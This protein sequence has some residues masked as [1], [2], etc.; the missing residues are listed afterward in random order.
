LSGSTDGLVNIIDTAVADEDEALV[1]I[2]NHGSSIHCG[3]FLCGGTELYSLSHDETFS[4]YQLEASS[5]TDTT[6]PPQV[7][8]DLRLRV[9]CD[10]VVDVVS[11]SDGTAVL[12]VGSHKYFSPSCYKR[13]VG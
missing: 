10:Y 3:G 1:Q 8:G 5:D 2:T 11:S 4:I 13:S 7:F 6:I 12:G 9:G